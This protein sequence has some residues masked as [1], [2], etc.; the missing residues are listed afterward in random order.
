VKPKSEGE[1]GKDAD[2]PDDFGYWG[3]G[4]KKRIDEQ[5][6]RKQA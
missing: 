1:K 3:L 6:L 5:A 4:E 2:Y